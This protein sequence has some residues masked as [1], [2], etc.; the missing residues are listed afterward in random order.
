MA[1]NLRELARKVNNDPEYARR[2]AENPAE[3]LREAARDT[4]PAYKSDIWIYRLV[5]IALAIVV[6]TAAAGSIVLVWNG[7]TTPE[8][9]VALGSASIGALAGLL[10]PSPIKAAAR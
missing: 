9:L 1:E 3:E 5:V 4:E 8:S 2:F 6:L 7:R 10:A